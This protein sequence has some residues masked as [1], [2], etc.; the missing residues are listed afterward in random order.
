[1][2]IVLFY[3][4]TNLILLS[5]L[6]NLHFGSGEKS[7]SVSLIRNLIAVPLLASEYFYF[8]FDP[9]IKTARVFLFS[10]TAFSL[11]WGFLGYQF[12]K[13][14][15]AEKSPKTLSFADIVFPCVAIGVGIYFSLSY[16]FHQ[17]GQDLKQLPPYGQA[18]IYSLILMVSVIFMVWRLERFWHSLNSVQRWEF[19]F[20]VIGAL[21][22]SGSLIWNSSYRLTYLKLNPGHFL[23]LGILLLVGWLLMLYA[24]S[25]HRLLNR[26]IFISRKIVYSSVAPIILGAYLLGLG[27]LS[28]IVRKYGIPISFVFMW[29]LI[30]LGFVGILTFLFSGKLRRRLQYFISTHFYVN[31]YE[32]RDEWLAFSRSL[33]GALSEREIINALQSILSESMYQEK[34]MIWIKDGDE[35]YSLVYSSRN[36]EMI[37]PLKKIPESDPLIRYLRKWAHFYIEE[38]GTNADWQK[39]KKDKKEFFS[40]QELVLAVPFFSGDQLL[41]VIG[42]GREFTGGRYGKDD[43][44]LLTALGTQGG[45]A[46]MAVRMAEEAARA[47]QLETWDALSTFV[48][49]DVKNAAN[50]LSLV[51]G[52]A[53]QHI[54]DPEFQKDMLKAVDNALNRMAKVQQRLKPL[55]YEMNLSIREVELGNLLSHY[56]NGVSSKIPALKLSIRDEA[57]LKINADPEALIRILDNLLLNSKEAGGEKAE[58]E[59]NIATNKD[60]QAIIEVMDNGPGISSE[61]LPELLFEPFKTTKPQGNGIG[62]W[63]VKWL[64]KKMKGNI[65]AENMS[66]GGAKFTIIL[67]L[68]PSS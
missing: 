54:G 19:K 35:G 14:M 45:Y 5:F 4:L 49:H 27:L 51:R 44:D 32:Y 66:F 2:I 63:Q 59:I 8:Y 62:L 25:M 12:L 47:K 48:I 52:N 56:R 33:K 1:M 40:N 37:G 30:I 18:Y 3:L 21:T 31:K 17:G 13:W 64:V 53:E 24:V 55:K 41:G 26:R 65:L 29:L 61:L 34:L 16:F 50:M 6:A 20:L 22:V 36:P 42:V 7:L 23:L 9:G 58:I 15:E 57:N 28:L 46:L 11:T 38:E 39:L 60:H 67:P 10:E 43:Y 68:S